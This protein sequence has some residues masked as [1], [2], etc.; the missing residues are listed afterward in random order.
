[1]LHAVPSFTVT[2]HDGDTLTSDALRGAPYVANFI[3]TTCPSVCPMLTS[4]MRNFQRRMQE[5]RGESSEALGFR[6][7]SFTVDPA[8]DTP[9][10]LKAY[11]EAQGA[12]VSSWRF[13]TL[14]DAE[15]TVAL[16]MQGFRVRMG[17]REE[18]PGGG[19]DIMHAGHFVLVDADGH[20]R[21]YYATDAEA[22]ARLDRELGA[23]LAD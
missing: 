14:G 3:F 5:E 4:Q 2:D 1:M 22:Q 12:D 11:A 9:D 19:Y 8:H 21:G 7:V 10:V 23:L 16:L 18:Q 6:I 13:V 20:V 17:E 15:A